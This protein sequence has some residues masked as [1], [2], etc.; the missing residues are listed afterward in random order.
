MRISSLEL[1][2]F[3]NYDSYLLEDIGPLTIFI[4]PN[5]IGKTNVLEAIDLMTSVKSFRHPKISELIEQGA[6]SSKVK[7]FFE[8]ANRM[9]EVDLFL[10][11]GKRR[12]LVNGKARSA[13][14]MRGILPSV[15][16]TPDDLDIAK[17][18]SGVKRSA[19]D[20]L[21]SQ[22]SKTYYVVLRDYEKTLRY[23]NRLLK[24]EAPASYVEA[25]NETFV[26][27]AAQL[28]SFRREIHRRMVPLVKE[29]YALISNSSESFTSTYVPSWDYV[30]NPQGQIPADASDVVETKEQITQH[31]VLGTSA[32]A[33]EEKARKRSLVGPHNDK[34]GFF[35]SGKD[36]SMYASQGQQR[37]IVLAWKLSEVELIKASTGIHPVLLLDDVMSELDES[38]RDMLVENVSGE[39]QTFMTST[40][41]SP[42]NAELTEK[43]RVVKLG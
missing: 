30:Q 18:S 38:R 28:H 33:E 15:S 7:T 42:F 34:I 31:L 6:A 23:K 27:C 1:V 41:L 29:K 3:R 35:L 37:S 17:K 39:V 10:E 40:D 21:G 32:F 11:E 14:D 22:L 43:A 25:L 9:L 20:E 13:A 8:D 24:E 26:T 36:A 2:N 16:F 5:G 4:G 19:L 12:Y